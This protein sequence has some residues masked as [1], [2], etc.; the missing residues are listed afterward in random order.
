MDALAERIS[1]QREFR[2][3]YCNGTKFHCTGTTLTQ[4]Q[5]SLFFCPHRSQAARSHW[6]DSMKSGVFSGMVQRYRMSL[7]TL[8]DV[9]GS[10]SSMSKLCETTRLPG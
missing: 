1:T 4:V 9:S 2:A 5:S 6:L 8:T 7:F 10:H 3:R